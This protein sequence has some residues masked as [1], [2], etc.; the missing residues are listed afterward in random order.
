MIQIIKVK[1]T[2]IKDY[3]K[4][5]G[6]TS[7][8][9]KRE[10]NSNQ[11][12]VGVWVQINAHLDYRWFDPADNLLTSSVR[13]TEHYNGNTM[14]VFNKHVQILCIGVGPVSPRLLMSYMT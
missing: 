6:K 8:G 12:P 7:V 11:A 2:Y 10:K 9:N 1:T 14:K 4:T 3:S 13:N 5:Q